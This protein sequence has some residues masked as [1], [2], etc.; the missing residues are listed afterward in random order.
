MCVFIFNIKTYTHNDTPNCVLHM[1]GVLWF[2]HTRQLWFAVHWRR[3]QKQM[4]YLV[5]PT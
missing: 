2:K 4:C 1:P 5:F 3:K